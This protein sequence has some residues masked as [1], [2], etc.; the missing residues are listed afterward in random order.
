MSHIVKIEDLCT[1]IDTVLASSSSSD[2]KVKRLIMRTVITISQ[3]SNIFLVSYRHIDE[4]LISFAYDG[5]S[6]EEAI[7]AYNSI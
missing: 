1:D 3:V 5:L 7:D 6:L 4:K 2:G